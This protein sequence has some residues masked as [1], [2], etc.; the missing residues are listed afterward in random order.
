MKD[1]VFLWLGPE[2]E[3]FELVVFCWNVYLEIRVMLWDVI[4]QMIFSSAMQ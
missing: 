2:S 4:F 3:I 1:G